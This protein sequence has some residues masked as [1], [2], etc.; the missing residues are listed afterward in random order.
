MAGPDWSDVLEFD[1][2]SEDLFGPDSS[3]P[4]PMNPGRAR[5]LGGAWPAEW[6]DS[7]DG[8]VVGWGVDEAI[9]D[10]TLTV[11]EQGRLRA[12]AARIRSFIE[13]RRRDGDG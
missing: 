5:R 1:F 12:F 10:Q 13:A 8:Y 4:L 2:S 9:L 6:V 3:P 7:G 11:V